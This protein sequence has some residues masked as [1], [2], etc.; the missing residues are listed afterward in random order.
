MK[1]LTNDVELYWTARN[2]GH[3]IDKRTVRGKKLV[4]KIKSLDIEEMEIISYELEIK[5]QF[6]TLRPK[7]FNFLFTIPNYSKN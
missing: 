4:A 1:D 3:N 6:V 7:D 5:P 2:G